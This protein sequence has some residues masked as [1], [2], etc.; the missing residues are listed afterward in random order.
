MG[1]LFQSGTAIENYDYMGQSTSVGRPFLL[2]RKSSG[3]IP[4][5]CLTGRY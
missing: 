3:I 5:A 1:E 4:A 2:Q